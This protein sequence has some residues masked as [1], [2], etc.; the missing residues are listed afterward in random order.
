M[1]LLSPFTYTQWFDDSGSPL[2]AGKIYTYEAG[3]STPKTTYTDSTGATAHPN[4]VI[5]DSGGRAIIWLDSGAYKLIAYTSADALVLPVY[6]NIVGSNQ[7]ILKGYVGTIASL[8]SLAAGAYSAVDVAGYSTTGDGGEGVFE[9]DA[10]SS[11]ADNTGT[12]IVPNSA[13][14]TGRWIRTVPNKIYTPAMFATA[15]DFFT[16]CAAQ[17]TNKSI[18]ITAD[19]DMDAAD[20]NLTSYIDIVAFANGA[21]I[22]N[23]TLTIAKFSAMPNYK[24]FADDLT[25]D[26]AAN[27]CNYA[28]IIWFGSAGAGKTRLETAFT[29]GGVKYEDTTATD[30]RNKL[31]YIGTDG[32]TYDYAMFNS[33]EVRA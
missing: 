32:N 30:E 23:G 20:I 21:T 5:L 27:A 8:K 18:A 31:K 11:T 22:S 1:A 12:I 10:A 16:W 29:N 3:T 6:D 9:W 33:S 4:P 19:V 24:V 7:T 15:A 26:F 17:S 28:Q 13:P 14:A 2:S 25:V